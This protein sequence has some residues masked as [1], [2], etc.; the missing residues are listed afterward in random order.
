MSNETISQLSPSLSTLPAEIQTRIFSYIE[1]KGIQN[2]LLTCN[3]LYQLGL[4][5]SVRT[6]RNYKYLDDGVYDNDENLAVR[7]RSLK[8]L[9]YI[10]ITK[11]DLA[12][13]VKEL[14][15]GHYPA[16]HDVEMD[17]LAKPGPHEMGVYRGLVEE[18]F[19]HDT[20]QEDKSHC[21]NLIEDLERGVP[22]AVNALI[23][24]VCSR[25]EVLCYV[26]S[27]QPRHLERVLQLASRNAQP[28]PACGQE[29]VKRPLANLR[30]VY[31]ESQDT[32]YGY[33][34]WHRHAALL[35]QL[36]NLS[37]YEIVMA[38]GSDEGGPLFDALPPRS[39]AVEHM[40]LRRSAISQVLIRHLFSPIKHLRSFEYT[41]GVYHMYDNEMMPRDLMEAILP[42]AETLE[43]LHINWED[44]W[45]KNGWADQPE[46]L[47]MGVELGDMVALKTLVTGMQALTG[48]LDAQ[49]EDIFGPELPLEVEGAPTL[50][51][52]LPENLEDLVIHGCGKAILD[53]A[54]EFLNMISLGERYK[55]LRRVR[56]AFNQENIDPHLVQLTHG[57]S[58]LKLEVVFQTKENRIYDLITHLASGSIFLPHICSPLWGPKF[59]EQWLAIRGM[60]VASA[61]VNQGVHELPGMDFNT[62]P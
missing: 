34:V 2:I 58:S 33:L 14:L 22:D 51:N 17:A 9:H 57:S 26:E 23:L 44:D 1:P 52:C 38:N 43:H 4:P 61:T 31:H 11:P 28:S 48:L 42:H 13:H 5:L 16:W 20:H 30:Q 40:V 25:V 27:Y 45:Y 24:I 39:S 19:A 36:P 60:D 53:Q 7:S 6:F 8:F 59:R 35:F 55:S 18:A 62:E 47:F 46:R 49:P 3:Q 29:I 41:R 56:F 10:T 12:R 15:F 54:Q 50:V 21:I 32:K 37:T